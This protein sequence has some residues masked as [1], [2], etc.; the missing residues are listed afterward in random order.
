V[1]R[2]LVA[3]GSSASEVGRLI[4]E[5]NDRVVARAAELVERALEAEGHGRPPVPYSWLA[6]GSE[7]RR[8]QTL[9]TDQDNGLVYADAAPEMAATA[10]QYFGRLAARMGA[11]LA[12]LGF[13]ECKGGFMASNPLWCQPETVWRERFASWMENPHPES[14]VAASVFFDLRPVAGDTATGRALWKWVCSR[15][16]SRTLFLR[17]LA[18]EALLREPGLGLFGRLRLER[19]GTHR[20]R[21]DLKSRG[22]FP[23]TQGVR[24]CALLLGLE[25]THTLDRLRGAAAHGLIGAREAEDL[26]GAYETVARLRLAHQLCCLDEGVQADNFLDPRRLGRADL[27]LLKDAFRTIAWFHR[28]VEDRFLTD[29]VA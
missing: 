25:D 27:L 18:R 17:H 5:L 11:A 20:G 26:R 28:F 12:A 4:A 3:G 21:L 8:E 10:A 2:W 13:P 16:P 29:T 19:T 15:A 6:A 1:V 9:R 7:A 23:V 24:V 14:L 22:I